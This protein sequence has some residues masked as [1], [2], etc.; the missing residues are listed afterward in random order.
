LCNRSAEGVGL[1]VV[2]ETAPAVDLHHRQPLTVLRLEGVV[3]GDVDLAK[4]EAQLLPELG[5]DAAGALAQVAA[6]GVIQN[7]FDYG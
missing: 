2:R 1:H 5:D 4:I 3:S 6:R 7:D